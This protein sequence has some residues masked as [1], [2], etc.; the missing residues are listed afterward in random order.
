MNLKALKAPFPEND[1]EWRVGQ[2]GVKNGRP[3]ALVLAYITARAVQER[4][5][6][7][8]GPENWSTKYHV[9]PNGILCELAI[10]IG[11]EWVVKTDGSPETQVE[12]FKGGI[13]KALVR[14]ASAWGVGR[15]LYGLDR[16]F[17]E[18][19]EEGAQGAEWG[20]V[21]DKDGKQH[22][23]Y[24][25]APKLPAWALPEP[26]KAAAKS[27]PK[28]PPKTIAP[29][30]EEDPAKAEEP[31]KPQAS[32]P[33][34]HTREDAN[35]VLMTLYRPYLTCYP[36]ASFVKLLEQRYGVGETNL[37]ALEQLEDLIKFLQGRIADYANGAPV[38]QEFGLTRKDTA[39]EFVW[40]FGKLKGAPLNKLSDAQLKDQWKWVMGLEN[41][42]GSALKCK[43][44]L[45]EYLPKGI[46]A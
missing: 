2:A 6:D 38:T 30:K 42:K 40:L 11:G 35:R 37:L 7:V 23:F 33:P 25:R 10:R 36:G 8:C 9:T 45:Q 17:A 24:W 34:K 46:D 26:G 13:S 41:P 1:V 4:L 18:I 31:Q 21:K 16:T 12:A 28:E 43:L 29:P 14:A 15:Y 20:S 5:D 3:W 44:A 19:T 22:Y 39:G 32:E 27:P